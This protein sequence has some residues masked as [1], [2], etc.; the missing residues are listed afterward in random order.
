[1]VSKYT[2][3]SVITMFVITLPPPDFPLVFEAIESLILKQFL[4]SGVP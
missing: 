1:M 2:V 4:P 3:L